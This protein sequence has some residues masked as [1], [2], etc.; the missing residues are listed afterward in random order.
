MTLIDK[1]STDNLLPTKQPSQ[2]KAVQRHLINRVY[3]TITNSPQDYARRLSAAASF[4]S[5]SCKYG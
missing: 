1:S 5:F 4:S 3:V 2:L